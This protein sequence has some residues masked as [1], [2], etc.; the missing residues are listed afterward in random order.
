MVPVVEDLILRAG[1]PGIWLGG[2]DA[3]DHTAVP[4]LGDL[5]LEAHLEVAVLLD[6]HQIAAAA[7]SN[8][9]AV[10]GSPP[11][12]RFLVLVA[13]P[14][15]QRLA[16]EHQFPAVGFFGGGQHRRLCVHDCAKGEE[17]GKHQTFHS[18]IIGRGQ[19]RARHS[20]AVALTNSTR[21]GNV[22][23]TGVGWAVRRCSLMPSR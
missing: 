15:G 22:T 5:P 8:E 19:Q 12:W 1:V 16:V 14:A 3:I 23:V 2:G 6:G 21:C 4:V 10:E 17:G 9:L 7:Q 13:A 18:A 11:P 20:G